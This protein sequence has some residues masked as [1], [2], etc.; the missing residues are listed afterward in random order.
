[1][2]EIT[3]IMWTHPSGGVVSIGDSRFQ[4]RVAISVARG[5]AKFNAYRR[6]RRVAKVPFEEFIVDF[7]SWSGLRVAK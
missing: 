7:E 1:M 2:K 3:N 6:M 4:R 5:V